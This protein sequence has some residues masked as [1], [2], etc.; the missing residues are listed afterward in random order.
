MTAVNPD[1]TLDFTKRLNI[2]CGEKPLPGF[3]NLDKK[4]GNGV[5]VGYDLEWL[6]GEIIDPQTGWPVKTGAKLPFPDDH[7]D[8]IV[9]SHVLEHITNILPLMQDLHR[10]AK[11]GAKAVFAVPFGGCDAAFEDPTHVR[12]FFLKSFLYFSQEMYGAADYGYSGDWVLDRLV[13][14]VDP[15]MIP[16]GATQDE[17]FALIHSSRNVCHEMVAHLRAVK[18]RRER[19][20]EGSDPSIFL[21]P[22]DDVRDIQKDLER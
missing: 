13:L 11:P 17:A 18:P 8:L 19:G 15:T 1:K 7:F 21:R 4:A 14:K 5:D 12:F 16:Q 9:G 10:V 2:G 22:I 20:C 3:V 6:K